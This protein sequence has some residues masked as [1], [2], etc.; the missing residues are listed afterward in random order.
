MTVAAVT[1]GVVPPGPVAAWAGTRRG[2]G[3]RRDRGP[4]PRLPAPPSA[5]VPRPAAPPPAARCAVGARGPPAAPPA[6][7]HHRRRLRHRAGR[8][9]RRLG[10]GPDR[11]ARG[12]GHRPGSLTGAPRRPPG[13]PRL[14]PHRRRL[15]HRRGRGRH[16]AGAGAGGVR[17][18]RAP[19]RERRLRARRRHAGP[20]PGPARSA[21]RSIPIGHQGLDGP[22]LRYFGG[23]TN[24]WAGY[25]RPFPELD[26]EP[27]SYVPRSGWP[28][29]R[30][31]L[32]PYYAVAQDACRL[33]PYD[34]DVSSW[35]ARGA[36]E[37]ADPELGDDPAHHRP[38]HHP[39][40]VRRHLPRRADA[41]ARHPTRAVGERHPAR[42][43]RRRERDQ[44]RRREDALRQR[45][46]GG[47]HGVRG[48]DRRARGPA[49][50][51]GLERQATGRA[52]GTSTTSSAATSWST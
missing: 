18:H 14:H 50:P 31:A 29:A 27:R 37:G 35:E 4:R 41:V 24:H 19:P 46:R 2:T 3:E 34:Y 43:R 17:S 36:L 39:A 12:R 22:R 5:R 45:V 42:A 33:G 16:H 38:A 44:H 11:S 48:G 47:G 6:H 9:R 7:E 10:A 1:T 49:A 25:C 30:A 51:P 13:R 21:S 28:M 15:H 20:L 26:F 32:E 40:S 52:S 23:T 8:Q